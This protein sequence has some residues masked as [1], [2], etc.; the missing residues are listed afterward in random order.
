MKEHAVSEIVGTLTLIGVVVLGIII[1]N[2]VILSQPRAARVPSIEAMI[3]NNS[4]LITITHQGGDTLEAGQYKILVDGVD[5]TGNFA[6]S[7][8]AG[9]FSAGETLTWNDPNMPLRVVVIYN[10]MGTGEVQI[11]ATRFPYGV[12]LPP[13]TNTSTPT[14]IVPPSLPYPPPIIVW[15]N[16][17]A[18]GNAT[19]SIQ[20]TDSSTGDN[21]DAYFWDYNDGNTSTT[22]SPA[23]TF[24]NT[25]AE[26]FMYSI[27]HSATEFSGSPWNITSWLNRSSWVT[28]YKNLTPTVTF[29]QD[30]TSG[31]AGCLL[32]H[33]DATRVGAIKVDSW[34]WSF[35][36]TGTSSDEDPSHTY[37]TQGT[38]TV[39]LTAT[40]FTLGQ[41]TVIKSN[42]IRATLSWYS[43]NWL[44]RKNITLNG[45]AVVVADQTNF[46]VLIS[47]T[48]TDLKN[49][50]SDNGYDILFTKD[51][52]T[53][54]LSHEIESFTKASGALV[55]WVKVPTL[56]S[57][58][59]TTLYMYYGNGTVGN[60]QDPTN[61]WDS[62]FK[63]VWHLKEDPSGTAPQM[64]DSTSVYNATSYGSMTTSDMIAAQINGGLDFDG[65]NDYLTNTSYTQTSVT[66]YTIEAW[67]KTSNGYAS[68]QRVIVHDR[69]SGAGKSLTLSIGGT[70]PG[71]PGAAGD[72]GYGCDSDNIY[73]GRYSTKTVNNNNWH[74]VVGVWTEPSGHSLNP[75]QFSIFIDGNAA[76]STTVSVNN[77]GSIVNSPLTGL[78]GTE[79]ARHPPWNTYLTA[80]LDEVRISNI[81]RSAN[82][83]KTEYNNQGSPSTFHYLQAQEVW[84]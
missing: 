58:T 70:Y 26:S 54:K 62:N 73:I 50:A 20:F 19:S 45:T 69:G 76:A 25:T 38:Y 16:A 79:I 49:N 23:H 10:G 65:S 44:Y 1:V 60:Q 43:C 81:V 21:I 31:P 55:A 13:N 7:G 17:P 68:T 32:V 83:I 8:G 42:L 78:S 34:S 36:D 74:H 33:F 5:Q 46:P 63:G 71:G 82:W 11:L 27:N 24:P 67:I 64:K 84:T 12:F 59:N 6:N 41:T 14:P 18:F 56:T 37:T 2:V 3:T 61:V 4:K 66:A 9:P 29:T 72:V 48:D 51:D 47:Y 52:G 80:Q 22:Q 30:R 39:S 53:T 40:N 77:S 75:A 15:T 28:V 57:G 35:G